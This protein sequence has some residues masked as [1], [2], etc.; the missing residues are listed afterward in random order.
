MQLMLLLLVWMT[1]VVCERTPERRSRGFGFVTMASTE[2]ANEAIRMFNGSQLLGRT[3]K[4]NFPEVPRGGERAIMGPRIRR[5]SRAFVDTP[6]KIYAGN[7]AWTVTSE[8]L[9]SAFEAQSGLVG[10]KVVYERD[11]GKSRGYGFVSFQSPEDAESALAA[12][13]GGE[14]EGRLLRLNL[15]SEKIIQI[16]PEV[17]DSS[18]DA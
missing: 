13:N 7:L 10:A 1:E 3:M 8:D 14:L 6:H 4:V 15:A 9:R 12:M 18:N 17:V 2:E 16:S 11:S 5:S